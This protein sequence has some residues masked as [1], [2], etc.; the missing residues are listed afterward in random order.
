LVDGAVGLVLE[1]GLFGDLL[2]DQLFVGLVDVAVCFLGTP[3]F[4]IL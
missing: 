4:Y 3:H 1:M 2:M